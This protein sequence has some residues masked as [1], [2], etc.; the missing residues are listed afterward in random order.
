MQV[1][2]NYSLHYNIEIIFSEDESKPRSS[3]LSIGESDV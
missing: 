1:F 3:D 2:E